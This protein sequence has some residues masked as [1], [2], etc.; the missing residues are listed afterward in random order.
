MDQ[1]RDDQLKRV[2]AQTNVGLG[3]LRQFE[4]HTLVPIVRFQSTLIY[5]QVKNALVAKY[6]AFNAFNQAEQK[7]IVKLILSQE[8]ILKQSLVHTV[9][10]LFTMEEF[11]FFQKHELELKRRIVKMIEERLLRNLEKLL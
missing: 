7:R 9:T 11:K 6:K 5:S 3:D 2:R 8:L 10:S 1:S 4:Q